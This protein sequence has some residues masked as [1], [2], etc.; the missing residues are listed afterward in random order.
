MQKDI[1]ITDGY[2]VGFVD[3]EGCFWI[4]TKLLRPFFEVVNN[5]RQILFAVASRIGIEPKIYS[6]PHKNPQQ[7]PTYQ[8]QAYTYANIEKVIA[9]F[10]AHQLIVKREDYLEFKHAFDTWRQEKRPWTHINNSQKLKARELYEKG[11]TYTTI[12]KETGV[13]LGSITY[14]VHDMKHRYKKSL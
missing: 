14:V 3:G 4:A 6:V 10:D 2:V 5:H 1:E 11:L 9:F 8:L 13:P 7:T 12:S